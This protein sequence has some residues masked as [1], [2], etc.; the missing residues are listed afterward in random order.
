MPFAAKLSVFM[1]VSGCVWRIMWRVVRIVSASWP[2]L[3]RYPTSSSAYD[4]I[5]IFITFDN[6]CTAQFFASVFEVLGT[7]EKVPS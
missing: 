5:K 1:G 6:M 2:L 4:T 3:K 7:H